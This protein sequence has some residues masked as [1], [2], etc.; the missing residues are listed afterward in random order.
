MAMAEPPSSRMRSFLR[1]RHSQDEIRSLYRL[2]GPGLL[3]YACSLLGRRHAAEDVLHQVFMKLLEQRS[4]PEDPKPYLFRSIRN[5]ALNVLQAQTREADLAEIEPW[6]EV[7]Q[8]D[9]AAEAGLR[10]ELLQL[11][12]EQRQV[13][14][15]HIWGGLTFEEIGALLDISSNTAASRYRYGLEK[16]RTRMRPEDIRY[17]GK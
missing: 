14:V 11:P 10:K 13:L 9:K 15:L 8:H 2:Y 12:M 5:A 3:L 7:P 4:L 16:L 1:R 17:A 6:F